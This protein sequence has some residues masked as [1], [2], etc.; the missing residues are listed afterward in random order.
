MSLTNLI[1]IGVGGNVVA[2]DAA[3]GQEVWRKKLKGDF[4]NVVLHE[5]SLYA[6]TRGEI[7]CLEPATGG[8]RWQN[9]LPG[10]GLGLVTFA[11]SGNQQPIP[12]S[13]KKRRD[14]AAPVAD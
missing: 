2:L 14:E 13:E 9:E 5:G 10:L 1:F 3:T 4:V 11:V 8:L 7:F 12:L 6:S